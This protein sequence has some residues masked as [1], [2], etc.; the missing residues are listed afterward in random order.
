MNT[1]CTAIDNPLQNE[2]GNVEYSRRPMQ[3]THR[4]VVKFLTELSFQQKRPT[5]GDWLVVDNRDIDEFVRDL[6]SKRVWAYHSK[7]L[8][9]CTGEPVE[10][11]RLLQTLYEDSNNAILAI[12]NHTCGLDTFIM[13]MIANLGR[14]MVVG[15]YDSTEYELKIGKNVYWVYRVN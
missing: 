13:T 3:A 1:Y 9:E 4:A 2:W 14:G 5:I 15:Q 8:S 11:F 6:V 10:V 12:I 7:A